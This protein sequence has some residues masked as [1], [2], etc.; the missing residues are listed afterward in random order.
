MVSTSADII[1][2]DETEPEA[3]LRIAMS[4]HTTAVPA[5]RPASGLTTSVTT[6]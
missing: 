6:T 1:S 4:S 3:I 2:S 5:S